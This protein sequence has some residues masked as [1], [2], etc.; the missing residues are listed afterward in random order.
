MH[1]VLDVSHLLTYVQI[2]KVKEIDSIKNTMADCAI[3]FRTQEAQWQ[4]ELQNKDLLVNQMGEDPVVVDVNMIETDPTIMAAKSYL[5]QQAS[6][7][8]YDGASVS[9]LSTILLF[10]Y[11]QVS[12]FIEHCLQNNMMPFSYDSI[13]IMNTIRW[14]CTRCPLFVVLFSEMHLSVACTL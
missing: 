3:D 1:S 10:L 9:R 6:T 2:G 4:D 11:L 14:Y 8:L 7:P 12:D 13:P 5:E